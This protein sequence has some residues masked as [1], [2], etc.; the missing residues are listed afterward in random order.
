MHQPPGAAGLILKA[1]P[2]APIGDAAKPRAL[3]NARSWEAPAAQGPPERVRL[4]ERAHQD[5]DI[6][7][8]LQQPDTNAFSLYH[9]YT[10]S[11]EGTNK[12]LNVVRTG[13]KVSKPS[14]RILDTGEDLKAEIVTGSKAKA[15]GIDLGGE[16]VERDQE[17]VVTDFSPVK[18]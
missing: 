10:E 8:F 9:D 15:A 17:D 11:R 1:K 7:Y 3:T 6:V 2:G 14:G 4:S 18:K 16:R 5:R 12:Y 13:S